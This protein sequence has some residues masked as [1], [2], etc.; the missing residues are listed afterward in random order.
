MR[1]DPDT[2]VGRLTAA[3]PTSAVVFERFGIP[4]HGN[5]EKSLQQL[6]QEHGIAMEEFLRAMSDIDWDEELPVKKQP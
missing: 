1:L 6:C 3:I 4:L 5:H 2:Q